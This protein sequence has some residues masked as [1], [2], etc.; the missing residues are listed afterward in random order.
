MHFIYDPP[1]YKVLQEIANT[2]MQLIPFT[3]PLAPLLKVDILTNLPVQDGSVILLK[4]ISDGLYS[5]PE[6]V[7]GTSNEEEQ[8]R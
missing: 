5:A 6:N 3:I 1:H 8:T 7:S 4:Y 2:H